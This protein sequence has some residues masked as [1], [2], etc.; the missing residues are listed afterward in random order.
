M[1]FWNKDIK[2]HSSSMIFQDFLFIY[3]WCTITQ[4]VRTQQ[5]GLLVATNYASKYCSTIYSDNCCE[6]ISKNVPFLLL[7]YLGIIDKKK[8]ITIQ[9]LKYIFRFCWIN[10]RLHVRPRSLSRPQLLMPRLF[11]YKLS[12]HQMYSKKKFNIARH[13]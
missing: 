12:N 10:I 4:L 11:D 2:F 13:G 5:L 1:S 3:C 7:W 8:C 9:T 6:E